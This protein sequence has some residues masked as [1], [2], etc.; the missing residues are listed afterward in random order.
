[1]VAVHDTAVDVVD[2][3]ALELGTELLDEL[4]VS[5]VLGDVVGELAVDV[6][7]VVEIVDDSVEAMEL[8]VEEVVVAK[9]LAGA[10]YMQEQA[11]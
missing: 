6:V 7:K 10:V 11:L 5:V 9:W 8:I 1:V 2:A 3:D 4:E